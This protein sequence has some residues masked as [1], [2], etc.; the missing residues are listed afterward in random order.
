MSN[1]SNN[2]SSSAEIE[3]VTEQMENLNI[4]SINLRSRLDLRHPSE[5]AELK[6]HGG[7]VFPNMP[8]SFDSIE[9]IRRLFQQA[10]PDLNFDQ[11]FLCFATPRGLF[12]RNC[13]DKQRYNVDIVLYYREHGAGDERKELDDWISY[14]RLRSDKSVREE[15]D[16]KT[17]SQYKRSVVNPA[18]KELGVVSDRKKN[19]DSENSNEEQN[20][21]APSSTTSTAASA[22]EKQND[23]VVVDNDKDKV[24]KEN[25]EK[26]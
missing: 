13:N 15:Y 5:I 7:M 16:V 22:L 24:E 4:E 10:K 3:K 20:S 23:D 25:E 9:K 1:N 18:L 14:T 12:P 2:N 19:S 17:M 21:A 6:N 8:Y 11:I 26:K